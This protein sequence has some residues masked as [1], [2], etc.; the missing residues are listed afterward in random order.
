MTANEVDRVM[1][2][3]TAFYPS[4][5]LPDETQRAYML[6]LKPLD[7]AA[8]MQAVEWVARRCT[9]WPSWAEF[10]QQYEDAV[11]RMA[12]PDPS[13]LALPARTKRPHISQMP[14]ERWSAIADKLL[15]AAGLPA[16]R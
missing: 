9:F 5:A 11:E 4:K 15:R 13:K 10:W 2:S 6:A 14:D 3:L 16:R 1:E 7:Y 8:A 12:V